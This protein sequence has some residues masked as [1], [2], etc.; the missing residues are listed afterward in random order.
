MGNLLVNEMRWGCEWN[1]VTIPTHIATI[2]TPLPH[3]RKRLVINIGTHERPG[4]LMRIK[5][6]MFIRR[7]CTKISQKISGK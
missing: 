7:F 3:L 2:I 6:D 1:F 5:N 4:R